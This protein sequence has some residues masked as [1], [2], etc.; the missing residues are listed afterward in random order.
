MRVCECVLTW[1]G[2][3]TAAVEK[4][5]APEL[6]GS[7]RARHIVARAL[8]AAADV[9]KDNQLLNRAIAA[10]LELL[11]MNERLSDKMLLEVATRTLDRIKFRGESQNVMPSNTAAIS[12]FLQ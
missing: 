10:Y 7:A 2:E 9:K 5:S 4:A 1:E 3:W 12:T 6:A 11:K 8:D